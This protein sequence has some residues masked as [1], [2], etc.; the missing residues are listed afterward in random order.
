MPD[1]RA[2]PALCAFDM[3]GRGNIAVIPSEVLETIETGPEE[4]LFR[5]NEKGRGGSG[6][7]DDGKEEG[8]GKPGKERLGHGDGDEA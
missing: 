1:L 8:E 2:Q 5:L 6:V 4:V 7:K 3:D